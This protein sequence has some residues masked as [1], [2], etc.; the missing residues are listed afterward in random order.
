M[1]PSTRLS[2]TRLCSASSIYIN[3]IENDEVHYIIL[4]FELR[5][6]KLQR[7]GGKYPEI[8]FELPFLLTRME[9]LSGLSP[10]HMYMLVKNSCS[11]SH[12]HLDRSA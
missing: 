3:A 1:S 12:K 11:H 6:L 7:H 8:V 10:I 9:N 2:K 5:L 4:S